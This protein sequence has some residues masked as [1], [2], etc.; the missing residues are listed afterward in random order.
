LRAQPR[1]PRTRSMSMLPDSS[2][3]RRMLPPTERLGEIG[4][5]LLVTAVVAAVLLR[6]L[7]LIA[8]RIERF[9]GRAGGGGGHAL[10]R[11]RTLGRIVRSTMATAVAAGAA[12][13]GLEILGWNVGPLLAGA[14]V[15]GVAVGFGAQT[16][17]RDLISGLFILA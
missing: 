9:I 12:I 2:V 16:L 1:R 6:L 15:L 13:H 11:A 8:K 3:I 10:Q 4:V 7:F 17:I 14:G 5:R